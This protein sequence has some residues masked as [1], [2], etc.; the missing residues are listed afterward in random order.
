MT[1]TQPSR[2]T[3]SNI[4]NYLLD[5]T[6]ASLYIGDMML[7]DINQVNAELATFVSLVHGPSHAPIAAPCALF[8]PD[9]GPADEFEE[10]L[11]ANHNET[12]N[13]RARKGA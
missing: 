11:V 2:T 5:S 1:A 13:L 3:S 6:P 7:T 10:T 8:V 9:D 12:V 4:V